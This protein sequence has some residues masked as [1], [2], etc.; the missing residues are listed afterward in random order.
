MAR[1][2]ATGRTF[3]TGRIQRVD[4][5]TGG[6]GGSPTDPPPVITTGATLVSRTTTTLEITWTADQFVSSWLEWGTT[7][8]YGNETTHDTSFAYATHA[9][10]ITGLSPSTTYHVRP[11]VVNQGGLTT[12]GANASFTTLAGSTPPPQSAFNTGY[13]YIDHTVPT[14]AGWTDGTDCRTALQSFLNAVP[15]GATATDH[16]RIVFPAGFTWRISGGV[17]VLNK[18]HWTIEGSGTEATYGHTGGAI[19]LRSGGL[20][21]NDTAGGHFLVSNFSGTAGYTNTDIRFHCITL[22]GDSD[23]H[24][25]ALSDLPAYSAG[26]S[27]RS[28]DGGRVNHCIIE[29]NRGDFVYVAGAGASSGGTASR[30]ILVDYCLL[31]DNERMGV[32]TVNHDS[33]L[34]IRGNK[35]SDVFYAAFDAEPNTNASRVGDVLIEG[36]LFAD[37][38]SWG[39]SYNDGVLKADAQNTLAPNHYGTITVQDNVFSCTVLN[40]AGQGWMWAASFGALYAK[41]GPLI[42]RNNTCTIPSAGPVVRTANWVGGVTMQNNTGFKTATGSWFT[43]SGNNGTIINTNNT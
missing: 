6:G 20:A 34:T 23:R 1:G 33:T 2:L 10:T 41:N 19:V 39:T 3:A 12:I 40:N 24:S 14:G 28:C 42:I 13:T 32:T 5:G 36:N 11:I 38:M 9:Q 17:Q 7:T 26:I 4:G 21:R 35:F 16:R 29:R 37:T 27:Y 30:D 31:Q 22:R 15:S 18:S 8:S 43:N 25:Q